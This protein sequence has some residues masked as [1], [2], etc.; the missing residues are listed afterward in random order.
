VIEATLWQLAALA[1]LGVLLGIA[2]RDLFGTLFA[3]LSEVWSGTDARIRAFR[4]YENERA[5]RRLERNMYEAQ[6]D[7]LRAE[8]RAAK[9]TEPLQ[10]MD[11]DPHDPL[12]RSFRDHLKRQDE[13]S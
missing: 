1:G 12:R 13:P 8:L 5:Q 4:G 3:L 10:P 6:L 9:R 7:S 11:V 2:L